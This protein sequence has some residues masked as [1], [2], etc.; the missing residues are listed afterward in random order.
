[1]TV[2]LDRAG[3]ALGPGDQILFLTPTEEVIGRGVV[4]ELARTRIKVQWVGRRYAVGGYEWTY[5]NLV[6][7]ARYCTCGGADY[8]SCLCGL[9][10]REWLD[11][12]KTN[13]RVDQGLTLPKG[14]Q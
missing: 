13:P 5:P 1:M 6:R 2:H 12:A 10:P 4:V 11:Y 8:V 14:L 9:T 3:V 7:K